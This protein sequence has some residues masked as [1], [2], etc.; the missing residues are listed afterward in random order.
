MTF[1]EYTR[2]MPGICQVYTWWLMLWRRTWPHAA[3]ATSNHITGPCHY[4]NSLVFTTLAYFTL[5]N[6]NAY[7]PFR[8]KERRQTMFFARTAH[9]AFHLGNYRCCSLIGRIN[10]H[11][12]ADE[13]ERFT[14]Q[15]T[16]MP[17]AQNIRSYSAF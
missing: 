6:V 13:A 8:H 5:A 17:M 1:L 16:A 3:R 9:K 15:S 7:C 10:N 11:K 14:V 2:Y 12:R 4:C